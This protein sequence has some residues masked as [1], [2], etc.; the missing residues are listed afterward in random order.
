MSKPIYWFILT[1]VC[2][3]C[4]S[5]TQKKEDA[6][7]DELTNMTFTN[8]SYDFGEISAGK[9]VSTLFEFS[10]TGENPL[11]I[12]EV[13]TSCGCTVLEWPKQTIQPNEKGTIKIVYDAKYPGRFN[14]TI[15][16]VYNGNDSPLELTIKGE[17]PYPE[18]EA[19]STFNKIK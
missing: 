9:S 8:K 11:L 14:K 13:T 6:V 7:L 10:N 15:M 12:K 17:V 4:D 19:K 1:I 3:S 18:K 5:K 16:V 2:I